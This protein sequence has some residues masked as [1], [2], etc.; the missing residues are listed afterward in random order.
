AWGFLVLAPPL[1]VLGLPGSFGRYLEYFR[2]RGHLKTVL[3]RTAATS[4]ALAS[5]AAVIVWLVAPQFSD[6]IFYRAQETN[7]VLLLAAGLVAVVAYNFL[8]ELLTALRMIRVVSGLQFAQS[9]AFAVI[10]LGLL[11]FWQATAISVVAA[12]IGA[13]ILTCIWASISL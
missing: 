6:I 8:V 12:Y 1:A 9:L 13:C 3:V 2:Q 5:V 4:A 7:I 11:H 10:G